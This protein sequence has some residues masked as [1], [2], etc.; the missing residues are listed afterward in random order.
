ME[1]AARGGGAWHEDEEPF[2]TNVC[3]VS[4]W[5]A[6][7]SYYYA[8]SCCRFCMLYPFC[9]M[10]TSPAFEEPPDPRSHPEDHEYVTSTPPLRAVS[11]LRQTCYLVNHGQYF[12]FSGLTY[13]FTKILSLV[14]ADS[15]L[16]P[17][18]PPSPPPPPFFTMCLRTRTLRAIH[19]RHKNTTHL[20]TYIRLMFSRPRRPMVPV[21]SW[22]CTTADSARPTAGFRSVKSTHLTCCLLLLL[23]VRACL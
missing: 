17:S 18:P 14:I 1:D 23:A 20:V 21:H 6:A 9:D 11:A 16:I 19:G 10:C 15:P 12:S 5:Q 2:V 8:T 13:P 7:T 22:H 4:P 3:C